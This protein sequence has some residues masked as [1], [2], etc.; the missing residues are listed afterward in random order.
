MENVRKK[1]TDI[2]DLSVFNED[3]ID[4]RTNAIIDGVKYLGQDVIVN[5]NR[6][7]N[8]A[9][10]YCINRTDTMLE[11]INA[12]LVASNIE[13]YDYVGF[14]YLQYSLRVHLLEDSLLTQHLIFQSFLRLRKFCLFQ[15]CD[16]YWS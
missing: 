15:F 6:I 8:F 5:G 11:N 12:K 1:H 14:L 3:Q 4:M 7:G 10:Q 16:F 9:G 13:S 2:H